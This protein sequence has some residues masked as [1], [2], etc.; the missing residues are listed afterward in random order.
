MQ[1]K[2]DKINIGVYNTHGTKSQFV[3]LNNWREDNNEH[4]A[5][6]TIQPA[7]ASE[8]RSGVYWKENYQ[9]SMR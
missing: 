1:K 3:F 5:E 8:D 9:A 4:R 2:I 6:R 7:R